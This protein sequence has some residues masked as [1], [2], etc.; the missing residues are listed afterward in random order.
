VISFV[1]TPL[2]LL[3][4][5]LPWPP[6]LFLAHTVLDGLM[7]FLFWSAAWPVWQAPVYLSP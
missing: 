3:A 5:V 7:A 4:A 1:V 2:A 6:I